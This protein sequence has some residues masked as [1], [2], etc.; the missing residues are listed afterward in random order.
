MIH[1]TVADRETL[2]AQAIA[3]LIDVEPDLRVAAICGDERTLLGAL[4][5][6]TCHVL[7]LEPVGFSPLEFQLVR[8]LRAAHPGVRIVILTTS[9]RERDL[10][11]AVR[12]EVADFLS[13][14]GD[15]AEV[16]Q[17]IRAAATGSAV[18][19]EQE[20]TRVVAE[21]SGRT[22]GESGLAPRQRD[23]LPG[24][25]QGKSNQ[26]IAVDL[27]LTEKTVKNY[28]RELFS[29]LGARNRTEAA[30]RAVQLDL[31]PEGAW[32][33]PGWHECDPRV[34]PFQPG[35]GAHCPGDHLRGARGPD[36]HSPAINSP[37]QPK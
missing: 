3:R 36:H 19:S 12:A 20:G 15:I 16:P 17:A 6:R 25:V 33:D 27:A 2:M 35:R 8:R 28:M 24:L 1:V 7:L 37:R 21:V 34:L 26:E 18:L 10:F 9:Q 4:A 5:A 29:A 14:F 13:K 31:V 23:L 30:I 22:S 32:A 11:V